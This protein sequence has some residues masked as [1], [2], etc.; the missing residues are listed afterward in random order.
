MEQHCSP[1]LIT[2]P[3]TVPLA[4]LYKSHKPTTFPKDGGSGGEKGS[5]EKKKEKRDEM[6]KALPIGPA[7][8]LLIK[9][10]LTWS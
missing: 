1:R 5:E 10:D 9:L 8:G 3:W 6:N 4:A 7:G 2:A